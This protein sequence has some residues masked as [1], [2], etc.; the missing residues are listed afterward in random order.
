[1]GRFETKVIIYHI[2]QGFP[3]MTPLPSPTPELL[4]HSADVT[5]AVRAEI[6]ANG[7]WISFARYMELALYAPGLGY[8][9][10][11]LPKFGQGGDFVTAP[12]ISPLFGRTLAR[13]VAQV[14]RL[15]PGDVL[16]LGAGTGRLAVQLLG[17]LQ[18]LGAVPAHYFILEVSAHLRAVQQ[19]TV[20]R[21]LPPE[22]ASRVQWLDALPV[23]FAGCVVGNEVLDALPAQLVAQ[24]D[25]GLYERGVGVEGE[26]LV[27]VERPADEALVAAAQPLALPSPYVSELC[28]AA[29]AL[30]ASLAAMLTQGAVLLLDYGFPQRE[31]YHPQRSGGTLMCHYRHQAHDDPLWHPGLQDITA[32]VD[33]TR[34]AEAALQHGLQVAGYASQ[35]QF[36]INCGITD[37]LAQVSPGDAAAYLPLAAAAQKLLSPAEMGELFKAIALTKGIDEPLQGFARGDKRHAL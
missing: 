4:A 21:E 5:A 14:L 28:P 11:G 31:Y 18:R 17:E 19:E 34:V 35:A 27:W 24:R 3:Q 8:Y 13:Q 29:P 16:E 7:G 37:L 20:Q 23:A 22:L 9:S 26:R 30:V 25:D 12:E 32:H 36:L 10:A 15:S 33:F 2:A 6:A 1:M